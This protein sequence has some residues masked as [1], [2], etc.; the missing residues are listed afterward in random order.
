MSSEST[1]VVIIDYDNPSGFYWDVS[2]ITTKIVYEYGRNRPFALA[3]VVIKK[4]YFNSDS[5]YWDEVARCPKDSD[6]KVILPNITLGETT[7]HIE[8]YGES[9]NMYIEKM[10]SNEDYIT[11][12]CYN[13][14]YKLKS[15]LYLSSLTNV[16]IEDSKYYLESDPLNPLTNLTPNAQDRLRL[17]YILNISDTEHHSI[18]L[19][20]IKIDSS[21]VKVDYIEGL[22]SDIFRFIAINGA[23][24][25]A[26]NCI[27][28]KG[29]SYDYDIFNDSSGSKGSI[30]NEYTEDQIRLMK[31]TT[32]YIVP[33]DDDMVKLRVNYLCWDVIKALGYLSNRYAF[34][35]DRAYFVDYNGSAYCSNF[36]EMVLDYGVDENGDNRYS[37]PFVSSL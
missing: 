1:P 26:G 21:N 24:Y 30:R 35:Y 6:G 18:I 8:A 19:N 4:A 34:F 17:E 15:A 29:Y 36:T 27:V 33:S 16:F 32:P 13:S 28:D 2:T 20:C 23:G 37:S 9:Y 5:L 10:T 3:E 12:L 31:S 11:L 7:I 22:S 25:D 14:A